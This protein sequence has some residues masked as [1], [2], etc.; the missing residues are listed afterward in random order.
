MVKDLKTC[1]VA[2]TISGSVA[3]GPTN[4]SAL[5]THFAWI[6]P[7]LPT[8]PTDVF[9][10]G[11]HDDPADSRSL[12]PGDSLPK[13]E[14]GGA[15]VKGRVPASKSVSGKKCGRNQRSAN[16]LMAHARQYP[17]EHTRRYVLDETH[18]VVRVPAPNE[19]TLRMHDTETDEDG[20]LRTFL[21]V[22]TPWNV[23]ATPTNILRHFGLTT[24]T[25][26]TFDDDDDADDASGTPATVG[27]ASLDVGGDPAISK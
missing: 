23:D 21:P 9:Y 20:V 24:S 13:Y 5:G 3:T 11:S 25:E 6:S 16:A 10:V 22:T 26:N 18:L 27:Q 14:Q 15:R 8:G 4:D 12:A 1:L 19:R 7:D 2:P 17:N